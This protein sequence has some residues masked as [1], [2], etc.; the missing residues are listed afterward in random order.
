[1]AFQLNNVVPWGRNL[2]EYRLMF[3]LSD[4]D[5]K[6]S[7]ALKVMQSIAFA[8]PELIKNFL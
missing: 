4:E 1:M 3:E 5:M 6:K 2:A 7:N 8:V